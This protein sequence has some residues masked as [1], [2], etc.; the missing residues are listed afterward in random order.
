MYAHNLN[1][2]DQQFTFHFR[3][4]KSHLPSLKFQKKNKS[5]HL[6]ESRTNTLEQNCIRRSQ[7]QICDENKDQ[8]AIAK[9]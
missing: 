5:L 4:S 1:A 7:L 9:P 3:N 6:N 8:N 2:S